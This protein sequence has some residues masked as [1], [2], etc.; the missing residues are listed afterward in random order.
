MSLKSA[1]LPDMTIWEWLANSALLASFAFVLYAGAQ[2]A[3]VMDDARTLKN[4]LEEID[5][6]LREAEAMGKKPAGASWQP[7]EYLPL[8]RV[9]YARLRES[10]Q[11]PFGN[12][13]GPIPAGQRPRVPAAT[14][15]Q[16]AETVDVSFW[17]PYTVEP[18]P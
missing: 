9:K 5:R 6:A 10:G 1:S 8:L 11:D 3:P 17:S 4:Q 15:T 12:S 18:A 16:V 2:R 14:Q 13:Y 7:E